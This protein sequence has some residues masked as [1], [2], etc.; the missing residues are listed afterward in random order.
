[1]GRINVTS[2]IF[3][4]P[5]GPNCSAP[6][7]LPR[8]KAGGESGLIL[9]HKEKQPHNLPGFD[10]RCDWQTKLIDALSLYSPET[11]T[12]VYT[13]IA[14]MTIGLGNHLVDL[15]RQLRCTG[16]PHLL[17]QALAAAGCLAKVFI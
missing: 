10:Q 11:A 5:T 9:L 13:T 6:P 16:Q 4:G 2:P 1:M 15:L 17:Q 14:P 7:P 3:A 8:A 12:L